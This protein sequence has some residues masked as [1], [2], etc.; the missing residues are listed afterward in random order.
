M[1]PLFH[2][3]PLLLLAAAVSEATYGA[4]QAQPDVVTVQQNSDGT[5]ISVTIDVLSNDQSNTTGLTIFD[6]QRTSDG[7]GSVVATN[8]GNHLVYTMDNVEFTGDDS[9][10]Y[11]PADD[12]GV[13][14]GGV[15]V[16]VRVLD[17]SSTGS[18][19]LEGP[20][21]SQI[22][23]EGSAKDTAAMLDDV[24]FGDN[25]SDLSSGLNE[26]CFQLAGLAASGS[27]SEVQQAVAE[28]TPEEVLMQRRMMSEQSRGQT[29]RVYSSQSLLR[30]GINPSFVV[31][32]GQVVPMQ[33]YKGEAAS[34]DQVSPWALF[35]S[36]HIDRAEHDQTSLESGYESDAYGITAGLDY[37]LNEAMHVGAALDWT[38]QEIDYDDNAGDLE[39]DFY[40]LTGYFSWFFDG[41]T[42]DVQFGYAMG[43][44]SMA[45]NM[46]F[47]TTS[48]ISADTD[49]D[50]FNLST[51]IDWSYNYGSWTGRPFLRLD[52]LTTSV[53]GYTEDGSNPWAM[54]VGD[55][56]LDQLTTSLGADVT[57]AWSTSWGVFLPS[58]KISM[59]S[60][61]ASEYEPVSFKLAGDGGS[62]SEFSLTPETEDDLFFQY[63]LGAVFVMKGG[64]SSFL[65]VQ[66]ISGY[67]NLDAYQI[68]GGV[69]FEL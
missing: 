45:R 60:E 16:T 14:Y 29:S 51:Q 10:V 43:D 62:S 47:P 44:I 56:D 69:N 48:T 15:L 54:E 3:V 23:K 20:I 8:D 52:Y 68:S 67:E 31:L 24:C 4:V 28:I 49:S 61:S 21:E 34:S 63:D 13:E 18:G 32:N 7:Y 19:E 12:E 53:D 41:F 6:W 40:N 55:Q 2:G 50:Q 39:S 46:T 64:L 36:V 42:W 22:I 9:F 58:F 11:Y 59:M 30:Q 25:H 17:A 57:Y 66:F 65:S 27:I 33:S 26:A 5:P 37:R 38:T 35:G 1:K